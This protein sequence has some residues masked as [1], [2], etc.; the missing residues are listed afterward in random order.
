MTE[1]AYCPHCDD[2]VEF[3]MLELAAQTG[4]DGVTYSYPAK[5]AVCKTCG[6]YASC[7]PYQKEMGEAFNDAMRTAQDVVSLEKV[8]DMP[9]RYHI[10]KRPLSLLLGWGEITYSRFVEGVVP[11]PKYSQTIGRLYD[12]PL[13]YLNL[14][15]ANQHRITGT[16]YRKSLKAVN[17]VL[18]EDYP[19]AVRLY[20]LA[21]RFFALADDD[22]TNKAMQKLVYYAQG[23]SAVLLGHP[24][25]TQEPKAWAAGPVYGQLWHE[26]KE[27]PSFCSR[28]SGDDSPFSREE[29]QLIE[30]MSFA[31]RLYSGTMLSEMTHREDPWLKARE[32]AGAVDG[33]ACKEPILMEDIEAYFSGVVEKLDIRIPADIKRYPSMA[34]KKWG[35]T[36]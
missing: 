30:A 31:F 19:D 17:A 24:I 10:G 22:L 6:S 1:Y 29:E 4:L 28:C 2:G 20:E 25:V 23:F 33:E 3:D 9:R 27:D 11:T 34:M 13:E 14:L 16:A 32:R 26:L 18:E 12:N 8:R 35:L 7:E 21:E 5:Q 15:K 36:S